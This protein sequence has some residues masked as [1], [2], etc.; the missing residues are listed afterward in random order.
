MTMPNSKFPFNFQDI[1][2]DV[3]GQN[4]DMAF[5]G[6]LGQA[7]LPQGQQNYFRRNV[8]DF[9]SRFQQHLSQQ[10]LQ[11]DPNNFN[12]NTD[13]SRSEDYFGGLNFQNEYLKQSPTSRGFFSGQFA[14]RTRFQ[15]R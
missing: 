8:G 12:P 6:R 3:F 9:L 10:F 1:S 11:A 5:L 14:P 15:F 13:L 7:N 2:R 4:P